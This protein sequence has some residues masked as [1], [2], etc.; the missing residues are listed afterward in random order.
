MFGDDFDPFDPETWQPKR[1][2]LT[3]EESAQIDKNLAEIN[4]RYHDAH[5]SRQL[6]HYLL[7]GKAELA[8]HRKFRNDKPFKAFI[9][10]LK[11]SEP[12][13]ERAIKELDHF[14]NTVKCP[15]CYC[16]YRRGEELELADSPFDWEKFAFDE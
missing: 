12:R 11:S 7:F 16:E 15:H 13:V 9:E 3:L 14:V 6:L 2:E 5:D 1:R 8:F 10:W 4:K